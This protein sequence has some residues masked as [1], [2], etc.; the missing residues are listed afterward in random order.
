MDRSL[1]FFCTGNLPPSFHPWVALAWFIMTQL[2]NYWCGLI[3]KC[4]GFLFTMDSIMVESQPPHKGRL[5]IYDGKT[6]YIYPPH[7]LLGES[8]VH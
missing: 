5:F 4:Q 6:T 3:T 2:Q 1:T 8:F 7:T